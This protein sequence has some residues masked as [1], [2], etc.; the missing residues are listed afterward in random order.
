MDEPPARRRTWEACYNA[1]DIGGYAT[2]DGRQTRWRRF[3]RSDN[4]C[5]LTAAG[6]A[7]LVTDGV[8]TVID[9]R[10]PFELRIDPY[11]LAPPNTPRD[12]P[13]YRNLSVLDQGD[14]VL[15]EALNAAETLVEKYAIILDRG[16]SQFASIIT[17]IGTAPKGG[18]LVYCHAG[19]D[20]TGLVAALVLALAGVPDATIAEDYAL[21]QGHLQLLYD[22]Q[23]RNAP[24][25]ADR[26][27]LEHQLRSPL[28]AAHP[29]TMLGT[30]AYL[31]AH[32]GGVH[33]YLR[34]AG[35]ARRDLDLV[36]AR[37]LD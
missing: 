22:H 8:R 18:V 5:R 11:P 17:A 2:R 19:K 9:L 26:E 27:R 25:L 23:I 36:R 33:A 28:N 13:E 12:A 21:S 34:G 14:K 1:R 24:N 31:D 10:S 4:L 37:L 29:K 15:D 6:A 3:F 32:Y 35:V 16:R 20:R 30:L 7:T